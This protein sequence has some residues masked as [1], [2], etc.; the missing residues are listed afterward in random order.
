[1]KYAK[2]LLEKATAL[3]VD[4]NGITFGDIRHLH[5]AAGNLSSMM[6]DLFI[7][8]GTQTDVRSDSPDE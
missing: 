8:L 7:K 6:M 1:M 4:I 3:D 2:A 5:Y